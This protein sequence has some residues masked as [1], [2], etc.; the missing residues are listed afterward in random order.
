MVSILSNTIIL[1]ITHSYLLPFADTEIPAKLLLSNVSETDFGISVNRINDLQIP[2][3][4][5]T[6]F[7]QVSKMVKNE[8]VVS[9]T[10]ESKTDTVVMEILT[11]LGIEWPLIIS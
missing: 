8:D 5:K 9:G 1:L 6:F 7:Y 4:A 2:N 11:S 10:S 3:D